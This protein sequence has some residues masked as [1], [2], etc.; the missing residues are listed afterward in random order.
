MTYKNFYDKIYIFMDNTFSFWL[1]TQ[2]QERHW[3]QSDLA[4]ASGLTRQAISYYLSN[5]SKSPDDNALICISK[6]LQ[7]PPEIV[8][9]A[10]GLLP[11]SPQPDPWMEKMAHYTSL[12][13]G[14]R[15]EL[16]EQL[17]QALLIQQEREET[18]D[19]SNHS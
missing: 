12:L 17:M 4:R 6:A 1:L 19:K 16:A 8:F 15:R 5:K 11:L 3:S 2:M 9:R 18:K 14:Q 13:T 7:L 10:A